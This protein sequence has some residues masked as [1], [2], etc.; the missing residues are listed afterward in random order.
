MSNI[1]VTEGQVLYSRTG[2]TAPSIGSEILV[3]QTGGVS[4]GVRV[5]IKDDPIFNNGE[6][7]LL[8]LTDLGDSRYKVTGGPSGRFTVDTLGQDQP[9][10]ALSAKIPASLNS[11][12][13]AL[14]KTALQR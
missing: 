12:S 14:K 9:F 6:R 2:K 5:E 7:V 13:T 1:D 3:V 11:L 4:N 10:S 8:F